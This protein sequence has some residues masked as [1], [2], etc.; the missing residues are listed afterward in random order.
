MHT[1]AESQLAGWAYEVMSHA[2]N[3][4]FVILSYS[5]FRQEIMRQWNE[6]KEG[7]INFISSETDPYTSSASML[8]DVIL[9]QELK[10]WTNGGSHLPPDHPMK[11]PVEAHQEGFTVLNDVFRGVHDVLG[12]AASGGQFG[13]KGEE[14]AWKMHRSTLSTVAHTALWCE[15]IGQ[16]K[17]SNFT[18][19]H[20]SMAMK[21]RPFPEQKSGLVP[22]QL[23]NA[24]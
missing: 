11:S 7:G 21:D 5:V 10:V 9:R 19:D 6:L 17:W 24:S 12:H 16:N 15:T 2:P 18:F 20:A 1:L 22:P 23:L 14:T 3:H 13:P 4:A 8:E